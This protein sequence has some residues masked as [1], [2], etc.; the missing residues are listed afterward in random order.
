VATF[1]ALLA[2]QPCHYGALVR[3]LGLL[4]RAGRLATDGPRYIAAAEAAAGGRPE[5]Q[6]GLRYC[7]GLQQWWVLSCMVCWMVRLG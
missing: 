7:Q 4:R 1:H 6:A 3:L 5:S 2:R